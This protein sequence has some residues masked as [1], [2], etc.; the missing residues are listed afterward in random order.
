M[1]WCMKKMRNFALRKHFNHTNDEK[2]IIFCS[3]SNFDARKLLNT[4]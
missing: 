3:F 1:T 4:G 2:N